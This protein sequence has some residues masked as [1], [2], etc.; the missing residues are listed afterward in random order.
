M[1]AL[2]FVVDFSLTYQKK[3]QKCSSSDLLELVIHNAWFQVCVCGGSLFFN[4]NMRKKS[5]SSMVANVLYSKEITV[6]S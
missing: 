6:V 3:W 2:V 4:S 5:C 1:I